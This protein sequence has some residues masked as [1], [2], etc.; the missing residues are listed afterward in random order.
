ME[1]E[2]AELRHYLEP[3]AAARIVAGDMR[4]DAAP[5]KKPATCGKAE[6]QPAYALVMAGNPWNMAVWSGGIGIGGI[7]VMLVIDML[8]ARA[9]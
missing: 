4:A 3:E 6:R 2:A 5:A 9:L 8:V 1:F 7:A